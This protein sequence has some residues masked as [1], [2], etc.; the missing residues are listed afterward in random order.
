MPTVLITGA[1]RGLGFEFARQYAADGWRVSATCRKP[2]SAGEL[3]R[4]A[5]SSRG[6]VDIIALDVTDAESINNR[7]C[8]LATS[9]STS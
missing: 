2:V 8:N 4:L 7:H 5:E 6:K 3:R 1:N 9:L